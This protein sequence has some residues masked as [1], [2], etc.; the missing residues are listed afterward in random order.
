[1][2][3]YQYYAYAAPALDYNPTTGAFVLKASYDP[4][5][6][7]ILVTITDDDATFDGDRYADEVGSDPNQ[8]AVVTRPDGTVIASGRI[9]DE[10]NAR[11][12]DPAGGDIYIDRI[13]IGGVRLGY[14]ASEPL[15]PGVSYGVISSTNVTAQA[16]NRLTYDQI[17]S[18]PCFAPGTMIATAR[19][20]K[21][22]ERLSADDRVLTLDHGYQPVLW[23][24]RFHAGT[25]S[26]APDEVVFPVGSLGD[27]L[28]RRPLRVTACH[29]L[30]LCGA[31]LDLH[32][33]ESEAL[34]AAGHLAVGGRITRRA[35]AADQRYHHI[36]LP[37]H[38]VILAD[39]VWA[40]SLFAG[41][42]VAGALPPHVRHQLRRL[43]PDS[44]RQ[45]A[46]I[47]LRRWEVQL[48]QRGQPAGTIRAAA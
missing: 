18:V 9:Y 38:E 2:A 10:A 42:A 39:G 35:A 41:G 4:Q 19:G 26:V 11:L 1:M 7:R 8:T 23:V 44:H 25:A 27:G 17:Q 33:G 45:T 16:G 34:A 32:F 15:V 43:S 12:A 31:H 37:D 29:R 46:R 14:F 6:D 48:A 36:L 20:E 5:I 22:V 3:T 28:P 13:E 47:C 24:G 21:P 30:L 40:E